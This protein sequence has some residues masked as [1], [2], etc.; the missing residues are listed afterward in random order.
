MYTTHASGPDPYLFDASLSRV[1]L[2][3]SERERLLTVTAGLDKVAAERVRA[4]IAKHMAAEAQESTERLRREYEA[5]TNEAVRQALDDDRRA[6]EGRR[7]SSAALSR[8]H[9]RTALHRE[10]GVRLQLQFLRR[11]VRAY[12]DLRPVTLPRRDCVRHHRPGTRR[13]R[14][15]SGSRGDPSDSSKGDGEGP[16]SPVAAQDLV[17]DRPGAGGRLADYAETEVAA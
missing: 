6:A 4:S 14:R 12:T 10:R 16:P 5:E 17:R 8:E 1:D 7:Q 13:V 15:T 11:R 3:R 9:A 2:P